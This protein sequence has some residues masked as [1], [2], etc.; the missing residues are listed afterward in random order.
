MTS[1]KPVEHCI[2]STVSSCY[3]EL[4]VLARD[5][6]F[7]YGDRATSYAPEKLRT[8]GGGGGFVKIC[9]VKK[10]LWE[11]EGSS[12]ARWMARL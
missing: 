5:I 6:L 3:R 12:S 8:G 10:H 7:Q 11:M 2:G 4:Q 1:A 9:R